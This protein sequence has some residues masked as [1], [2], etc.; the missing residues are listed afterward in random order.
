[1]SRHDYQDVDIAAALLDAAYADDPKET[2]LRREPE[3]KRSNSS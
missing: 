3:L 2:V 1:M